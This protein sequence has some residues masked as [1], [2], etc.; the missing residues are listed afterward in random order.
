M[1]GFKNSAFE[2]PILVTTKTL[3][4]KHYCRHQGQRAQIRETPKSAPESALRN[5][6]ALWSAPE[7]AL[8]GAP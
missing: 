3:L 1:N 2:A 7:S 6:G 4:L 5:R 8:E